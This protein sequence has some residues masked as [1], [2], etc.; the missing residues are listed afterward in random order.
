MTSQKQIQANQENSK[1]GGVKTDKG[2]SIV[3]KN[4]IKH[5]IT[6]NELIINNGIIN[7][8]KQE[9]DDLRELLIDSLQPVG[10]LEFIIV[11]KIL[12]SY[13]RLMRVCNYEKILIE[14]G[15]E[16]A[17]MVFFKGSEIFEI[18]SREIEVIRKEL[19]QTQRELK[20]VKADFSK[21][22]RAK[23]SEIKDF[24]TEQYSEYWYEIAEHEK[25]DDL[26][27]TGIEDITYEDIYFC[28][29]N[30]LITNK[31]ILENL[32]EISKNWCSFYK[33]NVTKLI[34]ELNETEIE[35]NH[36]LSINSLPSEF[37]A[38]K[39]IK[40]EGSLERQFY[41]A[42][43]QLERMQRLRKGESITPPVSLDVSAEID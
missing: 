23:P 24:L 25:Y 15:L 35:L 30:Q 4:A 33:K 18:N 31:T 19:N 17:K 42:L 2:K 40:Y 10:I 34:A 13:W 12:F 22:N 28:L 29:K 9:F 41:K 6:S 43:K 20:L 26:F 7:E 36:K 32:I 21:L 38:Q 14:S 11:K 39:I 37:E 3:K 5:G 8:S 27:S 1:K 16:H